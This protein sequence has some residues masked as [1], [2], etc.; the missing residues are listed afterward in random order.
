MLQ[1]SLKRQ[2]RNMSEVASGEC[3]CVCVCVTD[4]QCYTSHCTTLYEDIQKAKQNLMQCLLEHVGAMKCNEDLLQ[5]KKH[6]NGRGIYSIWLLQPSVLQ[7]SPN[8]SS[9]KT[10]CINNSISPG[11]PKSNPRVCV[12]AAT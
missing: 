3:Q 10:N 8:S 2:L 6:D 7:N 4:C 12:E 5:K 1:V 11:G 9:I